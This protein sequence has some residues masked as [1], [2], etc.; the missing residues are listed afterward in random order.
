V[1]LSGKRCQQHHVLHNPV[2]TSRPLFRPRARLARQAVGITSNGIMLGRKLGELRAAGLTHV[3]I[4]LDT[5]RPE[6]FEHMTRRRGHERVLESIE[7]ALALG[8]DPVKV[9]LPCTVGLGICRQTQTLLS[10]LLLSKEKE[11]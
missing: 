2:P 9:H 10:N 11:A 1:R 3:N 7:R 6:R 5:L 4:S 8:F